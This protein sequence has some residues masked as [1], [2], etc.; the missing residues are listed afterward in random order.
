MPED[1]PKVHVEDKRS[2]SFMPGENT[3]GL[4]G[5]DA[6]MPSS[7]CDARVLPGAVSFRS[8]SDPLAD[9]LHA[10]IKGVKECC[11]RGE[12]DRIGRPGFDLV[13]QRGVDLEQSFELLEFERNLFPDI[14]QSSQAPRLA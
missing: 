9:V 7:S 4:P 8:E 10:V 14:R 11:Q 13:D 12:L 3:A 5:S 6:D 2:S 1:V